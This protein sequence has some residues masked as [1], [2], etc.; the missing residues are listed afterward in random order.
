MTWLLQLVLK[1]KLVTILIAVIVTLLF[2]FWLDDLAAK[3]KERADLAIQVAAQ[4]TA[5]DQLGAVEGVVKSQAEIIKAQ[6][7]KLAD[8]VKKMAA[9]G[10]KGVEKTDTQVVVHDHSEGT[11]SGPPKPDAPPCP[12][13]WDDQY[14]RFHVDL[15][16]GSLDRQQVFHFYGAI[17]RGV[18]G[19]HRF[20]KSELTEFDPKTG[21]AIPLEGV[22][23][24][25]NFV[26]GDEK[27]VESRQF[28]HPIFVGGWTEKLAPALGLEILHLSRFSLT[29]LATYQ[30]STLSPRVQLSF[31]PKIPLLGETNVLIGPTW[32]FTSRRLGAAILVEITR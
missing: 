10:A 5:A 2:M 17:I 3:R 15:A 6:D 28:F 7:G 19:K 1:N 29:G 13:A 31:R 22:Q 12:G 26:F 8:F 18:D 27:L 21:E 9:L 32:D 25:N 24:T 23:Y 11:F 14:H 30:D 20:F 4:K 16:T